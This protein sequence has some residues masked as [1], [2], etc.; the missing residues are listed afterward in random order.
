[1][2]KWLIFSLIALMAMGVSIAADSIL[3]YLDFVWVQDDT[4]GYSSDDVLSIKDV[5]TSNIDIESPVIKKWTRD[6]TSY[7]FNVSTSRANAAPVAYWCF[8]DVS[9]DV[10]TNIGTH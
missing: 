1:M 10:N 2:K 8:Y 9:D 4:F 6:V 3:D 5:S 7:I